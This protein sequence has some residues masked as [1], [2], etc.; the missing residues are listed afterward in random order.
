MNPPAFQFYADDFVAGTMKFT[1]AEVGL[2]V[3]LLCAQWAEGG[4]PDDDAELVS[5]GRGETPLAR[6]KAKFIKGKDG[7]LRNARLEDVRAKQAAFRQSRVDAGRN[8]AANR[9]H[10]H[11]TANGKP[12]AQPMANGMAN[13]GSPSPSPSPS[14]KALKLQREKLFQVDGE[15]EAEV[16]RYDD[17]EA[18][19]MAR[20]KKLLGN[21]DC[22]NDGGKWRVRARGQGQKTLRV[23]QALESDAREG[24]KPSVSWAAYA[25]DT[26]KRFV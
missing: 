4:L 8:G 19:I 10:S 3:R 7:L 6:V 18:G 16:D 25:E 17:S 13:D 14:P 15:R 9:W 1:D 20:M 21:A 22:A 11:S 12:M 23:L 26:W 24:I 5:Y 2:Y